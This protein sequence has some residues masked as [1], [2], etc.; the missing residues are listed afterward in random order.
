[1]ETA[2]RIADSVAQEIAEDNSLSS[3]ETLLI[4]VDIQDDVLDTI[5][6]AIEDNPTVAKDLVDDEA[7]TEM[8]EMIERPNEVNLKSFLTPTFDR[9]TP[10]S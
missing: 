5:N 3:D 9:P 10:D 1:M 7:I 6:T 2:D 4:K 8:I